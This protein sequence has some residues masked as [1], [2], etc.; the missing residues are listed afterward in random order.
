MQEGGPDACW[1]KFVFA[2][3]MRVEV[4]AELLF[5][6]ERSSMAHEDENKCVI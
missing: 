5:N 2:L 4:E 6:F 3:E 1:I